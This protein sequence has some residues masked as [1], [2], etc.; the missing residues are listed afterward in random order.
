MSI[1]TGKVIVVE[2]LSEQRNNVDYDKPVSISIPSSIHQKITNL[3]WIIRTDHKPKIGV[4]TANIIEQFIE[5]YREE[6][7]E[8]QSRKTELF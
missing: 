5:E 3:C 6:I 2:R 7:I 8:L 4:V 1:D